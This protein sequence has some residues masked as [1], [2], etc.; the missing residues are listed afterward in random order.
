MIAIDKDYTTVVYSLGKCGTTSFVN[1][2]DDTWRFEGEQNVT[3]Y[4]ALHE[5]DNDLPIQQ[6]KVLRLSVDEHRCSP[7]F[8]VRD[9]WL[10]Y[11]S[12]I[13]EILQDYN[14]ALLRT[15]D[16]Q[17]TVWKELMSDKQMLIDYLGRLFYLTEFRTNEQ[18]QTENQYCW[19][20][21]FS[22]HENYHT[23][24]WLATID[25][26]PGARV[27][28]CTEL[29]N[30]I[31]ELGFAPRKDN[32]SPTEDLAKIEDALL[33]LPIMDLVDLHLKPEIEQYQK[34]TR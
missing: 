21:N 27:I 10:R 5:R 26:F 16:L 11:V 28:N 7:V 9:P 4:N 20:R 19:G 3:W 30:F 14:S 12:G 13:K 22:L 32:V 18:Y 23:R 1:A 8:I 15:R 24:N 25:Q 29:D 31:S 6:L 33:N 17:R 2:L 34:L